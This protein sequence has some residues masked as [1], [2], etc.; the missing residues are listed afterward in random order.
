[1]SKRNSR[2]VKDKAAINRWELIRKRAEKKRNDEHTR[3]R[4]EI[5]EYT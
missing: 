4:T 3:T 2:M 1:M 5:K